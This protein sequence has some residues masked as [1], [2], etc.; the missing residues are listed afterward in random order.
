LLIIARAHSDA[1]SAY[2]M[3]YGAS[4]VVLGEEEIAKA[5]VQHVS[6]AA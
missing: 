1:E 6:S 3:D 5:M 2:L 4:S